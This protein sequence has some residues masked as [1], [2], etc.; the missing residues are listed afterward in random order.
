MGTQQLI[1]III[2]VLVI[3]LVFHLLGGVA[4]PTWRTNSLYMPGAGALLVIV[5]LLFVLGRI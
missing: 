1:N 5:I 3:V 4:V 2:G